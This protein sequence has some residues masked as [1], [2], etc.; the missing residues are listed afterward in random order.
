MRI[1]VA[2]AS[3][4]GA[5]GAMAERIGETLRQAGLRVDVL[6]ADQ[7]VELQR[8][9]AMVLGSAVYAG[10]WRD[11][12]VDFLKDN[13]PILSQRPVWIFSSGP[14]GV[15][16]PVEWVQGWRYPEAL[17]ATI[18]RLQPRDTAVFHGY[19]DKDKLGLAERLLVRAVKAP[20]G[21]FRD[22]DRVDNWAAT[23][24]AALGEDRIEAQHAPEHDSLEN[25]PQ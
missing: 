25:A 4:Y 20:L 23:I 16:D 6:P 21:D 14:T 24:V 17:G 22:W 18:E 10:Q 7:T 3:K 5:T 2:Y 8:Y 19:L 9:D 15:G 12:A 1:L 13:E 11:E